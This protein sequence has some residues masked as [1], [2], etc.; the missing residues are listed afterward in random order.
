M[1]S[2]VVSSSSVS[3]PPAPS[4]VTNPP[5]L[6]STEILKWTRTAKLWEPTS[7]Y[8]DTEA[9]QNEVGDWITATI[10]PIHGFLLKNNQ[11]DWVNN[12]NNT[13]RADH[14]HIEH[15]IY[16]EEEDETRS[17]ARRITTITF[18]K[19]KEKPSNAAA[20]AP[21]L[22]SAAVRVLSNAAAAG[23]TEAFFVTNDGA[24]CAKGTLGY[25][26]ISTD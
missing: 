4:F 11:T 10:D 23:D 20:T 6:F 22:Y 24:T 15:D 3:S 7:V 5:H 25:K 13:T 14:I 26:C 16:I 21:L 12:N 8:P 18:F 9:S 17:K 19:Y 1:S 2:V